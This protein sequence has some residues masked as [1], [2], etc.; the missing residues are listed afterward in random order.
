MTFA[1][2]FSPKLWFRLTAISLI[3]VIAAFLVHEISS[4]DVWWQVTIGRD[5]LSTFSIPDQ[6]HFSRAGFG[7]PYHD[8][9]WLFQVAL[10]A[11]HYVAGMVGVQALMVGIWS[12]ALASCWKSMGKARYSLGGVFLVFLVTMA[13]VERFLPRPEIVTFVM[14]ALFYWRLR[15]GAFDL[16]LERFLFFFLQV[17]WANCHGLFVVGPFLVGC[18]WVS[19]LYKFIK[20]DKSFFSSV[21]VLFALVILATFITPFGL[22]GWKYAFLLFQEAGPGANEVLKSVNELSPTFGTAARHSPAFWSFIIL[23]IVCAISIVQSVFWRT[24][25]LPRTMIILALFAAALS[26]RRNIVLFALVAGPFIAE[27]F[28]P[29]KQLAP[30]WQNLTALICVAMMWC[31]AW[32]GF[33]G[34][35]Y[36]HMQIPARFGIGVTPSF[37]PHGLVGYLDTHQITGQVFNSNVAGGFFLYHHYPDRLPLTDGRWEIYDLQEL[38]TIRQ[39]PKQPN[40]WSWV[41]DK[42]D[43][44]A[45]LLLHA[46]PEADALLPKLPTNPQWRLVYLDKAASLWL[47]NDIVSEDQTLDLN[48]AVFTIPNVSR[49]DDA[50]ILERFFRSIGMT[51]ARVENLKRALQFESNHPLVL[52]RLGKAQLEQRDYSGAEESFSKLLLVDPENIE[53]LNELAFL[54]YQRK[55]YSAARKYIDRILVVDPNNLDALN[56][57]KIMKVN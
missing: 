45:L 23:M 40:A 51:N 54:A 8:S 21:S 26:G 42:Y 22:D 10:G 3:C 52:L 2:T 43:I 16:W 7:R 48:K 28:K 56:N 35:F 33:S 37:F 19:E 36:T 31:M 20:G 17:I 32:W 14:I 29:L 25:S 6:D 18:Y 38:S 1:T 27:Q 57:L 39:A 15:K 53:A 41:L 44:Q 49:I 55:E 12:V 9:H 47:R 34:R 5:I 11:V 50:L 46:S 4:L 13:S 24:L 30:R